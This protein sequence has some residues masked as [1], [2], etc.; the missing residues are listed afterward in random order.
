M[1][2]LGASGFNDVKRSSKLITSGERYEQVQRV[3]KRIVSQTGSDIPHAQWEAILI[4]DDS[5]NAWAMPGGKIGVNTGL[6]RV[7]QTEDE[8]A[9]VMGHE[10]AHVAARHASQRISQAL[11]IAGVAVGL[12]LA[13]RD[14]ESGDRAILL[15][16]YGIGTTAGVA[17]PFSRANEREAD[18]IGLLYMARAGY[19][20]RVAPGVWGKMAAAG[21]A[22][23]PQWLSTHPSH[24]DRERRLNEWMPEALL[25]YERATGKKLEMEK[26]A[27]EQFTRG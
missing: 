23:L 5:I 3:M 4:E 20:P 14:W 11:L 16:L 2:G 27:Y 26:E 17:L 10:V 6:F 13:T 7:T 12:D 15:G 9:F 22:S 24:E 1:A 21:G 18:Y 19:D 25:E 8:L